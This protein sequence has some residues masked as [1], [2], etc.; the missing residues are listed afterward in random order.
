MQLVEAGKI[1]LDAPVQRYL[2]WFRVADPQAS[3]QMTVRHLLN[4]TSGMPTLAGRSAWLISTIV[5]TPPSVRREPCPPSSS[6]ARSE[7][8]SSTAT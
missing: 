4:Q 5:Q 8:H 3:A 6:P 1:D 7:P 2:P